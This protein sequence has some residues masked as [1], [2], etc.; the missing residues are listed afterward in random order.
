MTDVAPAPN[1]ARRRPVT[2]AGAVADRLVAMLE[3]DG[4]TI[5]TGGGL[6]LLE[7]S[8]QCGAHAMARRANERTIVAAL[9]HD[10]GHILIGD[11]PHARAAI[12]APSHDVVGA[13]FL[14]NWFGDDVTYPIRL[15][16][17][18]RR[19]LAAVEGSADDHFGEAMT[20]DQIERFHENPHWTI[21]VDLRRWD[22]QSRRLGA[23][24]PSLTVFRDIIAD[25]VRVR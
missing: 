14:A 1:A 25:V 7:H 3:C 23:P 18:A 16:V 4:S 19:Y 24:A 5:T 8:L 15:H 20:L 13:R 10:I 6:S 2:D 17:E 12:G 9:L 21:A 11:R 22:E